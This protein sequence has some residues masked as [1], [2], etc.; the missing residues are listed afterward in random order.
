MFVE[1][2]DMI[3]NETLNL[4]FK[5]YPQPMQEVPIRR[6]P[7]APRPQQLTTMHESAL[8]MGFHANRE[9]IPGQEGTTQQRDVPESK[10]GKPQPVRVGEKVGRNDPCPCGSGKKH[11]QCHGK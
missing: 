6:Q 9:P 4:V 11:K 5:L 7:R 10:A 3:R 2:L 1:L 8:G